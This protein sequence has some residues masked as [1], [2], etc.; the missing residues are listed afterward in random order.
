MRVSTE[1]E[2][3]YHNSYGSLWMFAPK[4]IYILKIA[5]QHDKDLL[6]IVTHF[7]VLTNQKRLFSRLVFGFLRHA[8]TI[9]QLSSAQ[10]S[11]K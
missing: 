2:M 10:S 5:M 11:T 8:I 7:P 3:I 9:D 1:V 6:V 4:M